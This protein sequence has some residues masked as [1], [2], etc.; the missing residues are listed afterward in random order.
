MVKAIGESK[1]K[2]EED[3]IVAEEVAYLKKVIPQNTNK[4]KLKEMVV[5]ALYVEMLGQDASF[6]YMKIVELCASTNIA[7]KKAGYLAAS[8]CLSTGHEF[9]LMLVNRI[10]QDMKSSNQLEACAALSAVCKLV[11]VDMIPAVIGEVAN[12]MRHEMDPVRKRAMG[13]MHRLYQMDK[14]CITEH[15]DK[16]RRALCDKD[17]AVMGASLGLLLDL[18]KD[19]VSAFKD[20][21]PSLVSILKQI[22]EHKLPK[23]FDY[24]RIPA[25]WIQ[26]H[27]LRILAVLGRGDQ[28]SSE[29]MY[30]VLA[31]VMRRAD[32]GINVGYAIVYEA[33]NTV[34]SIYPNPLLLDAAAT[35]IS[36]FIRSDSHNLKYIGIK[37]LASIV[38]DHPRYAADHQ[39]AVIDCLE[40][41]DETLKRKTLDL[42]FRMTNSVNVVF[43]AD[44]LLSFLSTAVD[45]Y[46]RTE[47]V[48]QITQC[49]E[50]F[51]PSNTWYVRTIIKAFELAGDK[52]KPSVAQ[53]LTQL[54]AEG[55]DS[56]DDDEDDGD[57]ETRMT[58]DDELRTQAVEDFLLLIEKPKLPE[59]LIQTMAWVLGEYGY[60]SSSFTK[61]RIVE[62]LCALAAE[63]TNYDTAAHI[64]TA[65]TKLVAQIGSCPQRAAQLI[66]RFCSSPSLEMAQ[67]CREFLSLLDGHTDTLVDILPVDASCEDV[68]VDENLGWL[69][70]FVQQALA[71]GAAPYCP[72]PSA[73]DDEDDGSSQRSSALKMTPYD[74]PAIPTTAP[75]LGIMSGGAAGL[76]AV[77]T[78]FG[79]GQPL[80]VSPAPQGNQLLSSRGVNAVWGR[81]MP[82]PQPPAAPAPAASTPTAQGSAAF[83]TRAASP[84]PGASVPSSASPAPAPA[85]PPKGLSDKEKMAA[86]LFG[87][88]SAGPGAASS[89]GAKQVRRS[90]GGPGAVPV[91]TWSAAGATSASTPKSSSSGDGLLDLDAVS[92]SPALQQQQQQQQGGDLLL[93]MMG[94]SSPAPQQ[95]SLADT[96]AGLTMASPAHVAAPSTAAAAAASGPR[97]LPLNTGEFGQRWL[98][99]TADAQQQVPCRAASLE[100]L[101]LSMPPF[102]HHVESIQA[103]SEA[104]FS[105]ALASGGGTEVDVLVHIKLVPASLVAVVTVKSVAREV[106]AAQL[107]AVASCISD[108]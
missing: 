79:S 36:R 103:S 39:M 93:D 60:L 59:S 88:V 40:D 7:H 56:Q 86:A 73:G 72:P 81:N 89:A 62:S 38:K 99:S 45:D 34:T 101:R 4:K 30:E 1:S 105:A 6:A 58:K 71:A 26:M 5:R 33:V 55:A 100:A 41:P 95:Q 37:G 98:R 24:H 13:A 78:G 84:V 3:R 10:Q 11:T 46:F 82:P 8:L 19:N 18:C 57:G 102:L 2:Q 77:G 94:A 65:L 50:R 27:L 66:R 23:E 21:V 28:A 64:V 52:V 14:S 9:R 91:A 92:P 42:L 32:T 12:L 76:V 80:P 96:F 47:L 29:G 53:T 108:R 97:P 75:S 15:V 31:D 85:A 87:G 83:T 44:K 54:I 35:S 69:D 104:I 74:M 61:E 51:A 48:E 20:L 107:N 63:T 70:G 43:I 17:P 25:P 22:T 49:A 16:I 106:C 90:A 68:E 67:R